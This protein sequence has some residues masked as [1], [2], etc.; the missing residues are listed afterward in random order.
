MTTC[1]CINLQNLFR[2]VSQYPLVCYLQIG[3][4]SFIMNEEQNPNLASK[5]LHNRSHKT[6]MKKF[7]TCQQLGNSKYTGFE[8]IHL[9]FINYIP[10]SIG[11]K[12][13][14]L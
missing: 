6:C 5:C 8:F 14:I 9:S 7:K 10:K 1:K 4:L 11:I 12:N 13:S 3:Y 2:K